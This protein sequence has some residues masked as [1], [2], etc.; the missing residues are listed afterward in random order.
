MTDLLQWAKAGRGRVS[1]LAGRLGVSA[2]FAH[3]IIHGKKPVPVEHG[4]RIEAFT[5]VSRKQLFPAQW[6]EIWPEMA[7]DDGA[8]QSGGCPP[9]AAS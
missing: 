7:Q 1:A 8:D 2:S 9:S 5:G 3:K 4:A 6:Q